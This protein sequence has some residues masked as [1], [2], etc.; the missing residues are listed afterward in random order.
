MR[1]AERKL[2]E[3]LAAEGKATPLAPEEVETAKSL[4]ADGFVFLAGDASYA[5]VT[6]KGRR[7]LAKEETKPKRGKPPYSL[8]E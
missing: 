2:L 6:P 5:I 8:L 3:R 4:E 7:L 1:D